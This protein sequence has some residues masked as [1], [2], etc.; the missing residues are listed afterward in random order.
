MPEIVIGDIVDVE[1][2]I[3]KEIAAGDSPRKAGFNYGTGTPVKLLPDEYFTAVQV[4][5]VI[6]SLAH[7]AQLIA[8]DLS[9]RMRN[10]RLAETPT[11]RLLAKARLIEALD[12]IDTELQAARAKLV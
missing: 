2:Q 7:E 8:W 1:A 4:H 11:E 6:Q 10:A 5:S 3:A 9:E 12:S